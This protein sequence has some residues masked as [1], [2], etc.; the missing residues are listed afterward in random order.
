[1]DIKW[2]TLKFI[3]P[4]LK[5]VLTLFHYN[6]KCLICKKIK[7]NYEQ[8]L[9]NLNIFSILYNFQN[10]FV[11]ILNLAIKFNK[12]VFFFPCKSGF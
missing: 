2:Y 3:A 12:I 10:P 8:V 6:R 1:M 4:L 9:K 5:F 11:L 7:V